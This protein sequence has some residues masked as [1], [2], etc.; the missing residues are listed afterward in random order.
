MDGASLNNVRGYSAQVMS[1]VL[2]K[3]LETGI[4]DPDQSIRRTVISNLD[5]YFDPFLA[6]QDNLRLLFLALNDEVFEIRELVMGV[7]GRCAIR[8]PAY[9]LPGLRKKMIELL[10]E[11]EYSTDS[12]LREQSARLLAGL[13]GGP[14]YYI[15]NLH[16]LDSTGALPSVQQNSEPS[17]TSAPLSS[18]SVAAQQSSVVSEGSFYS[19]IHSRLVE[20]YV[21]AILKVLIPRVKD[22]DP[23]VASCALRAIGS[24][25]RQA[26]QELMAQHVEELIPLIV[27]TLQDYSSALKR[28]VALKCLGIVT[29]STGY[30]IKPLLHYPK[31]LDVL[32]TIIK[33]DQLPAVRHEVIKVLGILGALDPHRHRQIQLKTQKKSNLAS[34]APSASLLGD[35]KS[36]DTQLGSEDYYPNAA[37][38]ALLKIIKDPSLSTHHRQAVQ[39]IM[40]MNNSLGLKCTTFLPQIMPAFMNL[41]RNS[42]PGF[43]EFLLQ[44]FVVLVSIVKQHVRDFLSE[45]N[46]L[47]REYWA[48]QHVTQVLLLIEEV[49]KALNDEFRPYLPQIMPLLLAIL[50][51]DHS[52]HKLATTK[53]LRTL[54]VLNTLLDDYLHLVVPAVVKLFEDTDTDHVLTR[55]AIVTIG[56]LARRLNVSAY[57]ARIIQPLVRA[58]SMRL[59]LRDVCMQTLCYLL[60]QLREDYIIFVPMV[61][62]VL[63]HKNIV[64]IEYD[65]LEGHLLKMTTHSSTAVHESEYDDEYNEEMDVLGV[66]GQMMI[67]NDE[68]NEAHSSNTIETAPMQK[69]KL[70][71]Q[72]LRKAWET[73]ARLTREDWADWIRRFSIELLRESPSPALRS[74]LAVADF[75]PLVRELFNVGFVSCWNELP[76]AYQDELVRNLEAAL[77]SSNIPNEILQNLLDLAEFME[78]DD[79]PLPIDIHTLGQLS[80]KC[81]AYAKALHYLELEFKECPSNIDTI[82]AL[83]S[84]NN[85]L[86]LP[87]AAVGILKYAQQ[88]HQVELKESWYEKLGRWEEALEQYRAKD[89]QQ[90][91][92]LEVKLGRMRCL[93]SLGEWA[94]LAN[95]TQEEW[96]KAELP[97]QKIIAPMAAAAAWA[98]QDWDK[99][100]EYVRVLPT[101][102]LE[103]A[104]YRAVLHIHRNNFVK[105]HHYIDIT[106]HLLDTELTALVGE[107][108]QR[109]YDVLVRLQLLAEMEEIIEYKKSEAYP[110]RRVA[111]VHNWTERL[112]GCERDPDVW[113]RLLSVRSLVISAGQ[114]TEVWLKFAALCRKSDRHRLAHSTLTSLLGCDPSLDPRTALPVHAPRITFA[115]IKQLWAESPKQMAY[116]Y[117]Q[118]FATQLKND[119]ELQARVSL[120]LG[121]WQ[122]VLQEGLREDNIPTVLR[123][124]KA[125]TQ[126]DPQYYRAWHAW[127]MLNFDVIAFYEK[128]AASSKSKDSKLV[129]ERIRAHLVPAIHGFFRSIALSQGH[130]LQDTLRLL[131]LWFK[132]GADKQVEMALI[133]GFNT[134]SIDTWLQV[135][136]QIIARVHS[137]VSAVRRL[138]HGLL[139]RIG[140][141]H[142]QALVYPLTVA[143]KSPSH[144]RLA[145]ARQIMDKMRTHSAALVDQAL[146]VSKELIRVA[147]LW[148]ELWHEGLEDASR[149]YFGEHNVD[150]MF[151]VLG[152]LHRLLDVGPETSREAS[153]QQAYGREL[154]EA[155]E[156]CKKYSRSGKVADLNHA[157]DLYYHAFRRI[158]KQL[159]GMTTLELKHVSPKLLEAR[160]MELAVPGTYKPQRAVVRIAYFQPVLQ[161]ITS[162]QRP[163]KL[164]VVGSDGV[165]Y[166]FLLKGHEDL[167]QDERVMQLFG[168]VN[169]LLKGGRKTSHDQTRSSIDTNKNLSNLSIARY[170]VIPLSP[171]SGLI[172]WVPHCDTVH[173]L[174]RDYRQSRNIILNIEH[175]LMLQMSSDY[176]NLSLIQKVEVFEFALESTNGMDLERVLWLKSPNSEIWLERRTNY[177]RSLAVMSMVGYILG[178]GDRHPSNLMLDRHTGKIIHI[179]FGDCFEVAMQREKYPEK[180]PFRLTRMLTHAMEVSGI[181]GNFRSTCETVMTVLREH[182]ESLMAVLE[183]FVHDPLINWRLLTNNNGPAPTNATSALMMSQSTEDMEEDMPG[184]DADFK[185]QRDVVPPQPGELQNFKLNMNIN[186][187]RSTDVLHESTESFKRPPTADDDSA[188]SGDLYENNFRNTAPR[189]GST[190]SGDDSNFRNAPR[191]QNEGPTAFMPQPQIGVLNQRALFVINRVS[192]KLSGRDFNNEQPLSVTEQ[193]TKLIAQAT[194]KDNLCQCYIG[195]CPF[196]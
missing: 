168:L 9:V 123:A 89:Q 5:K 59:E 55:Q 152:P 180:I 104:F 103:G 138:L 11:L 88:T 94:Q 194:S 20:P 140:K 148:H 28:L 33:T 79:K 52:T 78:H 154:A 136:P 43:R 156:W 40:F 22:S 127:A 100:R 73:T 160:D 16:N 62:K 173:Q 98:L 192:N 68:S 119:N 29:Q 69:L 163:R 8:N 92:T 159:P 164:A 82:E 137:P 170:A 41:M 172:G 162:K 132:Y 15:N 110:E 142:P 144:Q 182:K 111:L 58:L 72:L 190:D 169:T 185:P 174:I 124:L 21:S 147:I 3:L 146:M 188:S 115:F 14:D 166:Y 48:T 76:E 157:W 102:D 139:V 49:S 84:I 176:D 39:A 13:I 25:A 47:I 27:E 99:M 171:N 131:T 2:L 181:E 143:S 122:L 128:Q 30:V 70:N 135:I 179:D 93:K 56:R 24:L 184:P 165:Q 12:L 53:A 46:Q 186:L 86:A 34:L 65:K 32:F 44:Q 113:Q 19:P 85:Q 67:E 187:L 83:I 114:D 150:G 158:N 18:A 116:H 38:E 141:E 112:K 10:S 134:L 4:S 121:Q 1:K 105:A 153:F 60:I 126:L 109:A 195:W 54:E 155:L 81:R 178:L 191:A 167:R 31:L 57:A 7:I 90:H 95:V 63:E 196:W 74:C 193:V 37:V 189:G 108:Y 64:H 145:A 35:E 130:N 91:S 42:E 50:H 36:A 26:P 77:L 183:A 175:R 107:S 87:E 177:T 66:H 97:A 106:R 80:E 117:L 118:Q 151:E 96:T 6:Q 133:D 149:L 61:R 129:A 75:Y 161:V 23:R 120:K 125:A 51:N 17:V 45:I 101:N 71:E